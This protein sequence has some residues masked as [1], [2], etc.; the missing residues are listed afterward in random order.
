M[1]W[2]DTWRE[3]R[4][5]GSRVRCGRRSGPPRLE[6]LETRAL[7]AVDVAV[8]LNHLTITSDNVGDSVEVRQNPNDNFRVDV[9]VGGAV[10]A[11][12]DLGVYGTIRFEGNGGN[13]IFINNTFNASFGLS[14]AC[15]AYG[16]SGNDLLQGNDQG[17][18]LIGG[19]DDD[20][21]Y[22]YGGQDVLGGDAGS[23]WLFGGTGNDVLDGGYWDTG[24]SNYLSG[25]AG[26]DQLRA[27][28]TGTNILNGGSGA[29]L[30]RPKWLLYVHDGHA[31]PVFT[32][33]PTIQDYAPGEGDAI[34]PLI[35]YQAV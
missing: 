20:I 28:L 22:G 18:V 1:S 9:L 26:N 19:A 4:R 34:A 6:V 5:D 27:S 30:L 16:G 15:E 14:R 21:L 31:Y 23:D 24:E 35:S 7:M 29:D 3:V 17:D 32:L 11:T 12:H 2:F 8:G 10:Q 13:D 33:M 25:E